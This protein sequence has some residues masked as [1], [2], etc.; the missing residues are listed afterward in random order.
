[1]QAEPVQDNQT[2]APLS[3]DLNLPAGSLQDSLQAFSDHTQIR[4]AAF[5]A[6]IKGLRGNGLRG[7][8][9]SEAALQRLL[10]GTGLRYE[11]IEPD[12][13]AIAR[14]QETSP[15]VRSPQTV[16]S[17][18]PPMP[19]VLIMPHIRVSGFR[20]S[21]ARAASLEQHA[22][23]IVSI[24]ASE[25]V[26]R[27][28]DQ[29]IA[30]AAARLPGVQITRRNGEGQTVQIRG[31]SAA[32]T[33]LEV[34]GRRT[35]S[36]FQR[37]D[38]T[39]ESTLSIFAPDLYDT[40]EIVKSPR[41]SD[42][43][44]GIG[45]IVRLTTK[46]P[47]AIGERAISVDAGGLSNAS[48]NELLPYFQL[49]Y[50]D[51]ALQ[52]RLGVWLAGSFREHDL[53][54]DRVE[55]NRDWILLEP[56]MLSASSDSSDLIG[57]RFPRRVRYFRQLGA[58]Q[59]YNIAGKLVYEISPDITTYFHGLF[60]QETRD[61]TRSRFQ[62]QFSHGL[63]DQ[64]LASETG[65]NIASARFLNPPLQFAGI[66]RD[67]DISTAGISTGL[68]FTGLDWTLRAALDL[69]TSQERLG[70]SVATHENEFTSGGV[71]YSL[72]TASHIPVLEGDVLTSPPSALDVSELS[73]EVREI[74]VDEFAVALDAEH[75]VRFGPVR[76]IETGVRYSD[77]RFSRRQG[78]QIREHPTG[79]FFSDA[80]AISFSTPFLEQSATPELPD[81][82]AV[83][84]YALLNQTEFATPLTFNDEN[85]Y[86]VREDV[87]SAYGLV[88]FEQSGSSGL[89][90]L[91]NAG[92]RLVATDYS[93]DA[94]ID[95]SGDV[96]PD[97]GNIGARQT[98][99][100]Y[101]DTL[102]SFNLSLYHADWPDM[103]FRFAASRVMARPDIEQIQNGEVI[104]IRD[105]TGNEPER[106][107]LETG[108]PD[109]DPY[110]ATQIEGGLYWNISGRQTSIFQLHLFAK[111]VE[112][113][114]TRV[115][116]ITPY[117][118][119]VTNGEVISLYNDAYPINGGSANVRGL[120]AGLQTPFY[121]LPEPWS[122][123][124]L[125]MSYTYTDSDFENAEGKIQSFP[126]ASDHAGNLIV[127]VDHGDFSAR[128]GY[129]YRSRF[130]V[131][132]ARTE[133][134][135]ANAIYEDD[136]QRL[137]LS[138]RY[139]FNDQWRLSLDAYNLTEEQ[140]YQYYDTP[141][142]LGRYETAGRSFLIR[143]DCQ[144]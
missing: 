56:D 14:N 13:I 142:R 141:S 32:F 91:G 5:E 117:S 59:R 78:Q 22:D 112:N 97:F 77:T 8:F 7:S 109:L 99:R 1:M 143:L 85:L 131:E 101:L 15:T 96:I 118:G 37:A 57:L 94:V 60:T 10:D 21:F 100:T 83:D 87:Y 88:V 23:Q 36:S 119:P 20:E 9:T 90:L 71:S 46:D 135:T 4:I 105:L 73:R 102:P 82:S 55:N 114:I 95:L 92:V 42:V 132:P 134:N 138:L 133:S 26:S 125:V 103:T 29:N 24:A 137:D 18:E 113:F 128:L 80:P 140:G 34:D 89:T 108:N 30:E 31:L 84:P 81:W 28:P 107:T 47:F 45:G 6:D 54:D 130:L 44:G 19:A 49:S 115:T 65:E 51:I 66:R 43:E 76:R 25:D 72:D 110:R 69:A 75:A 98:D 52:N 41:A 58:S 124:G 79:L 120:E 104:R 129:S 122:A 111:D 123:F 106:N 12:L 127:F 116:R 40:I 16:T 64:G 3:H 2:E 67:Q 39:R 17:L 50:S 136:Q 86:D 53:A 126:G 70:Q 68:D 35:S 74:H 27:F 121:F 38:P 93:G 11:I 144:F 62:V 139:R 63:L 48:A 33:R 61:E